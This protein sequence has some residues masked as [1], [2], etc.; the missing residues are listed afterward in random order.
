MSI[1]SR[2]SISSSSVN[3]GHFNYVQKY[4]PSS[5]RVKNVSSLQSYDA[6]QKTDFRKYFLSQET[7]QLM[8]H[9]MNYAK[10][11]VRGVYRANNLQLMNCDDLKSAKEA[12]V[13]TNCDKCKGKFNTN[14]GLFVLVNHKIQEENASNCH[15][16]YKMVCQKCY[17]ILKDKHLQQIEFFQIYPQLSLSTVEA[18]CKNQF[19]SKYLFGIDRQH[20]DTKHVFK[21]TILNMYTSIRQIIETKAPH[22][23]ITK[24]VL[25]TYEKPLYEETFE[26]CFINH[27]NEITFKP[28]ETQF[29]KF[30]Q[31]HKFINY[32]YFYEVYKRE[33]HN[34][35]NFNYVVYFAKPF[36]K[37]NDRVSCVKCK[38]KFYKK[39]H[40][41]LYCST[42]GFM[43][44]LHFTINED[45]IDLN[46]VKFFEPC[47]MAVK[48]KTHCLLYYDNNMYKRRLL[49]HQSS[50][51]HNLNAIT[52]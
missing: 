40:L 36:I 50:L 43:N 15:N 33:Y 24:I 16:K 19:V 52:K 2:M 26:E 22:E 3:T 20:T 27:L 34:T 18:L 12:Y 49:Q 42:C 5:Q 30:A 37:H 44:R 1:S 4:T 9:V 46:S 28:K 10:N 41:V 17:T 8:Q 47:V 7:S 25:R 6:K 32:T 21:D 38:N 45:K 39:Q 23:H 51:T 13:M 48:T 35:M 29:H 14:Q 31:T 11:Y